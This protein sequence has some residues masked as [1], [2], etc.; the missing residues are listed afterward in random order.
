MKTLLMISAA[1]L[2]GAGAAAAQENSTFITLDSNA[3]GSV[4]YDE[5]VLA[6]PTLTRDAFADSDID[7]DGSLNVAEFEAWLE[8]R[9]DAEAGA[10]ADPQDGSD[11]DSG[12]LE[13]EIDPNAGIDS[14]IGTSQ[15]SV[16]DDPSDPLEEP[17]DEPIDEPSDEPMPE[18]E[19]DSGL[20]AEIQT[21]IDDPENP[22][23]G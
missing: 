19:L 9:A 16:Y 21:E 12:A 23:R 13:S 7:G 15:D 17:M 4:S 11:L 22:M 8:A 6:D 20:D 1:T 14:D 18:P 3:N 10:E 5:A 2:I